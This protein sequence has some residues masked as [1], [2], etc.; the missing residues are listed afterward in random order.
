MTSAVRVEAEVAR[1]VS[2]PSEAR[3]E[4]SVGERPLAAVTAPV[5]GGRYTWTTVAHPFPMALDGVH[6]LRVT[7]HGGFRLAAFRCASAPAA[8]D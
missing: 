7:T 8:A 4:F 2:G 3:L 6:D 1:A 5:T